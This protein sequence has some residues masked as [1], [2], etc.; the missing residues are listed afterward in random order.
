MKSNKSLQHSKETMRE[1]C[2]NFTNKLKEQKLIRSSL[3][4][5]HK[6][7]LKYK[8]LK[9]KNRLQLESLKHKVSNRL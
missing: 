3:K 1:K 4:S 2:I 6:H 8:K 9:Q 5:K 7:K